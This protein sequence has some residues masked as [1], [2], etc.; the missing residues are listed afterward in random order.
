MESSGR[1]FW[2]ASV[3]EGRDTAV[4]PTVAR[5]SRSGA[6]EEP[7]RS[8]VRARKKRDGKH[9]PRFSSLVL[10][11]SHLWSNSSLFPFPF[12]L[13][14]KASGLVLLLS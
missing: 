10:K 9:R 6:Q 3:S 13:Y 5:F 12:W 7:P 8:R 11:H 1:V 14:S 4:E 2:E